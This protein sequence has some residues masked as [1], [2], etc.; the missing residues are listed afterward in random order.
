MLG[1]SL[2]SATAAGTG[3][4]AADASQDQRSDDNSNI[5][6]KAV[7]QSISAFAADDTSVWQTYGGCGMSCAGCSLQCF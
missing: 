4:F 5:T 1:L 2:A 7:T 6:T 3:V